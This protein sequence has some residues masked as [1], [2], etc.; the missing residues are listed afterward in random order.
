MGNLKTFIIFISV[1]LLVYGSVNYLL[2]TRITQA[3]SLSGAKLWA[4]RI[5]LLALIISFP[6]HQ[7]LRNFGAA[8]RILSWV[9]AFWFG[10]MLYGLLSILIVD[11]LRFSDFLLGWFPNFVTAD[12]VATGR[13][14][15]FICSVLTIS[16]LVGGYFVSLKPRIN[17][18]QIH[19]AKYR[20]EQASYRIVAFSD[21]HLGSLVG[22]RRLAKL[23]DQINQLSPDLVLIVGDL[24]D[25]PVTRLEWAEAHLK[26]LKATDGV[27]AVSGNHEFYAGIL[28]WVK[29]MYRLEIPVLRNQA[30]QIRDAL[31]IVGVDDVTATRQFD[32]H[33]PPIASI[34]S[35]SDR[36][37][38]ILLLHHT[39]TRIKEASD[40]GVDIMLSGH[41]HNG[42]LWPVNYIT[43]A[44]FGYN[45]GLHKI[46]SLNFY[47]MAGAGT[48]GPPARPFTPPEVL[49]LDISGPVY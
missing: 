36:T 20:S 28:P 49:V 11:L 23:V 3:L 7:T 6:L 27:F 47:L 35:D 9:G 26:R 41:T 34:L 21:F 48:W 33:L 44:I 19:L 8:D 18:H 45:A 42:Q 29:W 10:F 15:L 16:A 2:L 17:E 31:T 25:E 5:G 40:A 30:V 13:W 4:V 43:K 12:R 46:D 32:V 24:I 39:P 22:D 38:P 1:V 37:L 14:T